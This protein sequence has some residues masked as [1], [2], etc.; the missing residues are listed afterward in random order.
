MPCICAWMNS[1]LRAVKVSHFAASE[2][3]RLRPELRPR[4]G[5]GGM[6][7]AT[8]KGPGTAGFA[9]QGR[10]LPGAGKQAAIRRPILWF[11]SF[12]RAK[13]MNEQLQMTP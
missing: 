3:G 8:G 10:I 2:H 7:A 4:K 9:G 6:D 11:V 5:G 13:E 1:W 12:G